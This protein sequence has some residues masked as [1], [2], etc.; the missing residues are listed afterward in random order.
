[1]MIMVM[2]GVAFGLMVS[3]SRLRSWKQ[4]PT[5]NIPHAHG[6]C[7]LSSLHIN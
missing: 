6:G 1:M 4:T 3:R 2:T 5:Y 7:E